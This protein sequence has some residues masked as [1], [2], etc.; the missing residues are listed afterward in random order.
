M[1][2]P[3]EAT[4]IA[5]GH[6]PCAVCLPGKYARWKADQESTVSGTG[7]VRDRRVTSCRPRGA[8]A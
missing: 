3:D 5:A 6:R 7:D 2:F 8:E 4:A 1:F